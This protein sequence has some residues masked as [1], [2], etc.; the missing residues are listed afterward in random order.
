MLVMVQ[1]NNVNN[2]DLTYRHV[3]KYWAVA[4]RTLIAPNTDYKEIP[5]RIANGYL[6]GLVD[7]LPKPSTAGVSATSAGGKAVRIP[8]KLDGTELKRW[9]QVVCL[10]YVCNPDRL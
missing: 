9:K 5:I 1:A 3:K 2:S 10:L 6:Q 8:M 7:Q 4:Y